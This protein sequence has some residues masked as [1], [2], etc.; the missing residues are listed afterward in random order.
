MQQQHWKAQVPYFARHC[1]VVT[2]DPRGNGGSDRP[3]DPAAYSDDEV[4]AD[5]LAMLDALGIERA[6]L[7]SLSGGA[8]PALMLA[9]RHPERVTAAAFI[10]PYVPFA[11]SP[12]RATDFDVDLPAV[13]GLGEVQPPRLAT[14][15]PRLL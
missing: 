1:R 14:R 5:A 9:A 10:G 13:R 7:V 2:F 15:L 8:M 4:A 12:E 6:G 11:P 3:E